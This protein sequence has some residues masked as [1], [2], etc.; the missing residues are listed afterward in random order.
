MKSAVNSLTLLVG[1]KAGFR[2]ILKIEKTLNLAS[3]H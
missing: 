2:M 3:F 1:N